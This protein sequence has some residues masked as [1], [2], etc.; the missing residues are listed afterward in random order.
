[1]KGSLTLGKF[2]DDGKTLIEHVEAPC[3]SSTKSCGHGR[4]NYIYMNENMKMGQKLWDQVVQGP[5]SGL[6]VA[7]M[8]WENISNF[9]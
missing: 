6:E 1:M 5:L 8:N 7:T 9:Y 2:V 3:L 4:G